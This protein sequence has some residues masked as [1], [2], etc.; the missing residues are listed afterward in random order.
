MNVEEVKERWREAS[1]D[2]VLQAATTDKNGYPPEIQAIIDQEVQ[3]RDLHFAVELNKPSS[4]ESVQKKGEKTPIWCRLREEAQGFLH[5][6]IRDVPRTLI[7]G[8]SSQ[9]SKW[10]QERW[11]FG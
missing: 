5:F 9:I 7:W 2:D 4:K 11:G 6:M 8:S 3:R 1:D 10:E